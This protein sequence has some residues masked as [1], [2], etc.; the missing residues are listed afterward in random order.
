MPIEPQWLIIGGVAALVGAIALVARGVERKRR[1]AY[2]QHCLI[3]GF[4]FEPERPEGERRFRDFFEPFNQGHS[5][6]WSY[7]ISGQLH[8]AAFTA[9]EYRWVTGGGKSSHTHHI[10][11]LVWEAD[12]AVFPQFSLTPEGWF[13]RLGQVFGMQDID[14]DDAPEFSKAYRLKG[15]NEAAIR[16]LFTPEMRQFFAVTLGRHVAGGGR[17]LFWW[18]DGRLPNAEQ[19]DE[20]LELGDQ[21]R[22]RFFKR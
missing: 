3:R 4:K 13:S 20:W 15:P 8:G 14:F 22:R 5:R 17:F 7:T 12:D 10:G 19:L 18:V 9:F 6:R 1:E 11:G 2:E 16:A 21:V